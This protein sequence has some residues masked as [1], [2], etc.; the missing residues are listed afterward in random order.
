MGLRGYPH[1]HC[2]AAWPILLIEAVLLPLR[3]TRASLEGPSHIAIKPTSPNAFSD[4]DESIDE[5]ALIQTGLVKS[6]ASSEHRPGRLY[7]RSHA[8]SNRSSAITCTE[9]T[10]EGAYFSITVNVGTPPQAFELV[11]DSGS[12]ALVIPDCNCKMAGCLPD[13]PCFDGSL[14][15]TFTTTTVLQS[16]TSIVGGDGTRIA[17]SYGSGTIICVVGSD[18]VS[19]GQ[20]SAL[21][22]N[23]L[24]MMVD[25][26]QLKL[27]GSFQGIFGLGLDNP[28]LAD[29]GGLF[30]KFANIP[31]YSLCFNS[32][33]PGIL[34]MD[35]PPLGNPLPNIGR[36]HWGLD[37]Q[38]MYL[39]DFS[40]EVLFCD[41]AQ[42]AEGADTACGVIPD[43]GTTLILGPQ[44]QIDILW[45][46]I[47]DNWPR[48]SQAA[49]A[50]DRDPSITK[51][52]ILYNLLKDCAEW[53]SPDDEAGVDEMPPIKMRLGGN[54][55]QVQEIELSP[56]NYVMGTTV[57]VM[58]TIEEHVFGG[59]ISVQIPTGE[60]RLQCSMAMSSHDYNTQKNGPIWILG[61]PLFF[62]Y[63][64]SFDNT[65]DAY[66]LS[67]AKSQGSCA[68]SACQEPSSLDA[69]GERDDSPKH[70]T[71]RRAIRHVPKIRWPSIDAT[72][73]IL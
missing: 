14:S 36:V 51:P 30:T 31:R 23:A 49:A 2:K 27:E 17:L 6:R 45:E 22:P 7:E 50:G 43:T 12:N 67:F 55:G 3:S 70:K 60:K 5:V 47:C 56:F 38:G 73:K 48:C 11:V 29:I 20:T 52:H 59:T 32:E 69:T 34:R 63:T 4:L 9:L 16:M 61:S 44:D 62:E 64:V 58:R 53:M 57:D 21:M 13:D 8:G 35:L 66:A 37:L 40:G 26:S 15:T 54:P 41:P 28:E 1:L 10:N 24:Y 71:K 46:A 42:K 25:R 33:E 65:P 39:G 72:K 68:M 19:A 18:I